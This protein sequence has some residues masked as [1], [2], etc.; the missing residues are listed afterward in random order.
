[1]Y[2]QCASNIP[3][4]LAYPTQPMPLKPPPIARQQFDEARR[5]TKFT[6]SSRHTISSLK[7]PSLAFA[8]F[9]FL[10]SAPST[11]SA[12]VRLSS[13]ARE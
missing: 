10:L 11:A 3:G 2:N 6:A 8:S 9:G 1:M 12:I 13:D 4:E 5:W 7:N